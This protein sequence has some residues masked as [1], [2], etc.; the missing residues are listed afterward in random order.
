MLYDERVAR[1]E[2][3]PWRRA[4]GQEFSGNALRNAD[5]EVSEGLVRIFWPGN[6]NCGAW[7]LAVRPTLNNDRGAAWHVEADDQEKSKDG[8]GSY[9]D[10]L[11]KS[12][13]NKSDPI[14]LFC[15]GPK[16]GNVFLL[17]DKRV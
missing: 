2:C 3:P 17:D 15:N 8:S 12:K 4:P 6:V 5:F 10:S 9:R 1:P 13:I 11:E 7:R 14:T 16:A